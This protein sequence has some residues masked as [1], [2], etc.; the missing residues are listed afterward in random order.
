MPW[1]GIPGLLL[2]VRAR[3]NLRLPEVKPAVSQVCRWNN[4]YRFY[5]ESTRRYFMISRKRLEPRTLNHQRSQYWAAGVRHSQTTF[6]E[7]ALAVF[8]PDILIPIQYLSTYQRRFNLDPERVLMLA[9]LQD[10]VVCF[11]EYLGSTC[12]RKLNLYTDAEQWLLNDDRSY[13]FSFENICEA[14]GFE[15]GYLRQGLMRWK[16]AVFAR[17]KGK[18]N[19][20]RLAS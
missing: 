18:H 15:A 2:F 20:K 19:R 6:D 5:V 7:K 4:F 1:N 10:A 9:V 11:Q 12:K 16:E 13:L 3:V 17:N 14:L 8:Q